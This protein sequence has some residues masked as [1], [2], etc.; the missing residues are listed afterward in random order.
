MNDDELNKIKELC[1]LNLKINSILLSVLSNTE[2]FP[3][4]KNNIL[5]LLEKVSETL[6]KTENKDK[7][8]GNTEV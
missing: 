6:N 2:N 7:R 5:K 3:I 4:P 1:F 8:F